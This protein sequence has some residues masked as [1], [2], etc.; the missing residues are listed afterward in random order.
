MDMNTLF[1]IIG[2]II[3]AVIG[4]LFERWRERTARLHERKEN[5]YKNLV[6]SFKGFSES[7]PDIGLRIQFLDEA[8]L[9]R[10]YARDDA[11]K[12]L[13][14][15]VDIMM[16][17]ETQFKEETGKDYQEEAHILLGKFMIAMRK[18]LGMNTKL[19]AKEIGR[20]E[21]TK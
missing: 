4:Y 10:L 6:L 1:T 9:A 14:K 18:D 11:I 21:I 19:N 12:A 17:S 16:K 20:I 13:N 2:A 7:K 15:L 8:R 3:V 5:L